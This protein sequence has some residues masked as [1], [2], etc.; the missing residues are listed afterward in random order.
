MPPIPMKTY[1]HFAV[2]TIVLTL[3]IAMF[4]EGEGA[5]VRAAREAPPPSSA[6]A[7]SEAEIASEE[8]SPDPDHDAAS[9]PAYGSSSLTRRSETPSSN[10]N[11]RK[12][13]GSSGQFG[14]EAGQ[15]G[16][17]SS[18][19]PYTRTPEQTYSQAYLDSL[20]AEEREALEKLLNETPVPSV[21]ERRRQ[22][23][24]LQ[25]ASRRRS[26]TATEY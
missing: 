13:A 3:F 25:A 19:N 24:S 8:V 17:S 10:S 11:G 22:A 9:E 7:E 5:K 23:A 6:L 21:A 20:T 26:G 4:A 2:I 12:P 14:S 15:S 18:I 16:Q 1:R